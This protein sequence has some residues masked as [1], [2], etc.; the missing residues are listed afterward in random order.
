MNDQ[1]GTD[2][3]ESDQIFRLTNV[4]ALVSRVHIFDDQLTIQFIDL[5]SVLRPTDKCRNEHDL[6]SNSV[7]SSFITINNNSF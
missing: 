4:I 7:K 3:V 5:R 2:R 1:S 6:R